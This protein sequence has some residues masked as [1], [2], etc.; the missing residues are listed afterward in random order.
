MAV[1]L[2][3]VRGFVVTR[4]EPPGCNPDHGQ[5][6]DEEEN[7]ARQFRGWP[8]SFEFLFLRVS[9]VRRRMVLANGFLLN[10]FLQIHD[11]GFCNSRRLRCPHMT[12]GSAS[13]LEQCLVSRASLAFLKP[14]VTPSDTWMR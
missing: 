7:P 3:I 8:V 5:P 1:D 12:F 10:R 14:A 6:G 9:L 13:M 4:K 2:G 11:F